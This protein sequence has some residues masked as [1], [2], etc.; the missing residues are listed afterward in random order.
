MQA[1]IIE[2]GIYFLLFFLPLAFGGVELWAQ[3]VFQTVTALIVLAWAWSGWQSPGMPGYLPAEASPRK[4]RYSPTL[5]IPIGLFLLLV[6]LQIIPLPNSVVRIL[7]P[8][9]Y[10]LFSRNLPG[11]AEGKGFEPGDVSPWLLR[12]QRERI[13]PALL[14]GSDAAPAGGTAGAGETSARASSWRPL[15]LYPFR[16]RLRLQTLLCY[17]ALFAVI[18]GHYRTRQ[19]LVRLLSVAVLSA[20]AVSFMGILQKLAWNG[21]LYWIREGS[22]RH[23]F[24]PYVNRNQYAAFAE[25]MLPVAM[26][27]A[28]ASLRHYT[29][30]RKEAA[31]GFVFQ[32]F[33][34]VVIAAGIFYSLSRGGMIAAGFSVVVVAIFLVSYGPRRLEMLLMGAFVVAAMGFLIWIGPEEVIERAGT[35]SQGRSAPSLALRLDVWERTVGLMKDYPLFG[36]GLGSFLFAF[37]PYGPPGRAWSTDAHSEYIELICETGFAGLFLFLLGFVAYVRLVWHPLKFHRTGNR[38]LYAGLAAGLAAILLHSTISP[39]LRLPANGLAMTIMAA[40]LLCLVLHHE[41]RDARTAREPRAHRRHGHR[42]KRG[43]R[44]RSSKEGRD[45]TQTEARSRGSRGEPGSRASGQ[46]QGREEAA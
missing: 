12:Q 26:C 2:G 32:T 31:A 11:Y 20:F 5:W 27:M 17:V 28:L 44:R 39:G 35:I 25:L 9:A 10:D 30:G 42:R 36:T 40:A 18:I 8:S 16:T 4:G 23:V 13:P 6:L 46:P 14:A 1:V 7:S 34:T 3:G 41:S 45:E 15:T 19:R 38:Y 22:Y 37:M 29:R 24:G 43:R 33:A 21:K